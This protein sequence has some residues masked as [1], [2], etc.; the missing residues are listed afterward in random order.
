M[1]S[2]ITAYPAAPGRTGK[3]NTCEDVPASPSPSIMIITLHFC[4][5]GVWVCR[6]A[7]VRWH[8]LSSLQPP[9][10][11]F[12]Q[13]SRLSLLSSWDYRHVPSHLA[14][15]L[16]R[17]LL[18]SPGWSVSPDLMI[19]QPQPSSSAMIVSLS[20]FCHDCESSPAMWNCESMKP[21]SFINYP[22][23]GYPCVAQAGLELLG[24]SH[25]PA[26]ASQN[27]RFKGMRYHAQLISAHI[28]LSVSLAPLPRLDCND[29]ILAHCNLRLLVSKTGFHHVDQACLELLTSDDLPTSAY[30]SAGITETLYPSAAQVDC[31]GAISLSRSITRQGSGAILADC[32]FPFPVSSN[33][34]ASASQMESHSVTRLE[35]SDA[36]SAHCN[37]H[38]LSSSDSP[39]LASQVAG[40]HAQTESCPGARLE[41][42]GSISM[43]CSLCLLGLS[44]SPASASQV[45]GIIDMRHYAQLIFVFLGERGFHHVGQD[46]LDHLTLLECSGTILAHCNL[47][48]P[49]SSDSLT[50]ASQVPGT[51]G[52]HHYAQLIFYTFRTGFHHVGQADLELLT[53]S[54]A[55]LGLS[56]CW[57]YRREP[58]CPILLNIAQDWSWYQITEDSNLGP[59]G[60]IVGSGQEAFRIC[61]ESAITHMDTRVV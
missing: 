51:I 21:P 19:C 44:D 37:L 26:L 14:N 59:V 41:C 12:K 7:G 60:E 56:K 36:V 2:L 9:P 61:S 18:C 22:F 23:S 15:F 43:H 53:S 32:N 27:G 47:C 57:D 52:T 17:I 45:A 10:P 50:S 34:P 33:S 49:G 11:G 35:C 39:A 1:Q 20:L 31:N 5:D 46:G 25:P 6:Q 28:E 40:T 4:Y 13:F 30:Q 24:S 54:S 16:D 48:L 42:S 58:L 8:D 38:H 3:T 29:T 55:C